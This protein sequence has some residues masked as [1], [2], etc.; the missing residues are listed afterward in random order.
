MARAFRTAGESDVSRIGPDVPR[1]CGRAT[2]GG[3]GGPSARAS[4]QHHERDN[5][6][7]TNSVA[8]EPAATG[9]APASEKRRGECRL[10]LP[11]LSGIPV[12]VSLGD[13]QREQAQVF[14]SLF[15][16]NLLE[17]VA[18]APNDS[19]TALI[20]RALHQTVRKHFAS[21]LPARAEI[22]I[23]AMAEGVPKDG[24][25]WLTLTWLEPEVLCLE[26]LETALLELDMLYQ[27]E[28]R[29]DLLE[30]SLFAEVSRLEP[31][32][33]LALAVLPTLVHR[34]D[35][36]LSAIS[37]VFGPQDAL[38]LVEAWSW[39]GDASGEAVYAEAREQ[40]EY[41]RERDGDSNLISDAA[42]I[43]FADA[44]LLTPNVVRDRL[45]AHHLHFSPL[46]EAVVERVLNAWVTPPDDPKFAALERLQT[47]YRLTKD[48]EVLTEPLRDAERQAWGKHDDPFD[49]DPSYSLVLA[50]RFERDLVT[51]M[52]DEAMD[53]AMQV[54]T[55]R[56]GW[57]IPLD[58]TC[59]SL[60]AVQVFFEFAPRV[61]KLATEI[62]RA[63]SIEHLPTTSEA[64]LEY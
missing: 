34:L 10:I 47:V 53:L 45:G 52:F 39:E 57:A 2:H 41:Q 24:G 29:R 4:K 64:N 27:T 5:Q 33:S 26:P 18:P 50:S 38:G 43:A 59:E 62:I 28:Q 56:P 51:E 40:L 22:A 7:N 3:S 36:V 20:A 44:N 19:L 42:V 46:D 14:K 37:P 60:E 63:L 12:R 31:L 49:G 32:P 58:G 48:L 25:L 54:G 17:S 23:H 35:R 6:Y 8:L 9:L 15:A 55:F 30:R 61:F 13:V 11:R 1:R 16:M 21:H